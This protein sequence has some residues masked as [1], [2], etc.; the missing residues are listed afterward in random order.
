M[1]GANDIIS[2][3]Q[4]RQD[5]EEFQQLNWKGTFEDYLSIVMSRPAVVRTAY[6]RI[7]DM[8]MSHG[9]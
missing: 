5:T 6:Q 9:T 7:Y 1:S 8:I 2:L 4:S 3:I